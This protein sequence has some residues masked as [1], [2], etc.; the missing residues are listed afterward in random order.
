VT[1]VADFRGWTGCQLKTP[2]CDDTAHVMLK[3]LDFM[4]RMA[5]PVSWL[6]PYSRCLVTTFAAYY[7]N[8]R[9]LPAQNPFRPYLVVHAV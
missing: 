7:T 6:R 5:A 8:I 2:S 3:L 9:R 1:P 4:I